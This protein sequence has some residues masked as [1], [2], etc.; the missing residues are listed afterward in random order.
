MTTITVTTAQTLHVVLKNGKKN[1]FI[2]TSVQKVA[3][4]GFS[5]CLDVTFMHMG[6]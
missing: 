2:D 3:I 1:G 4:P 5:G 6:Q